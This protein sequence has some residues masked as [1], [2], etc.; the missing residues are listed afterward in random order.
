MRG[1]GR[2]GDAAG[3]SRPRWAALVDQP[4]SPSPPAHDILC[5][6]FHEKC[7]AVDLPWQAAEH[8]ALQFILQ[9]LPHRFAGVP[10]EIGAENRTDVHIHSLF[11]CQ[12]LAPGM[13]SSR[14]A[15]SG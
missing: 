7:G 6:G 13:T 10:W 5:V 4:M 2:R 9:L 14:G 12:A 3:G 8:V 11:A 15:A 1:V